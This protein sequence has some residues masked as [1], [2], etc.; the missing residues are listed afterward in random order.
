MKKRKAIAKSNNKK[1]QD[2]YNLHKLCMNKLDETMM[3][4]ASNNQWKKVKKEGFPF[5]L[6][7]GFI[8]EECLFRMVDDGCIH[9]T[10][11]KLNFMLK[12][13]ADW[14]VIKAKQERKEA[15]LN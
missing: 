4:I 8:V 7:M 9:S 13:V 5:T 11:D 6:V 15:T 14:Q 3:S 2:I 10:K 1:D 12:R